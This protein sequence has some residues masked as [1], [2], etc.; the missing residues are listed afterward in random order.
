MR[1]LPGGLGAAR[2]GMHTV[3]EMRDASRNDDRVQ[4]VAF[5]LVCASYL[6]V[7]VGEQLL[8]P[9]FPVARD[10]LGLTLGDGGIAFGVLTASIAVANLL[11]GA[12]LTRVGPL[13]AIQAS[14]VATMIGSVIAAT[15]DGLGQ[16]VV[17]QVFMGLGAGLFFPGGLQLIAR[18]AG[19]SR[20][21]MA[22]GMYGVAFSIALTVAAVLGAI[23]AEQGWRSA[24]WVGGAIGVVALVVSLRIRE[25]REPGPHPGPIDWRAVAGLPTVV[26]AVGAVCQYGSIP[27]LTTFAVDRWGLREASAAIVLAAGRVIS[28]VAKL[29]A[30]ASADRIGPMRSAQRTSVV[31]VATGLGWALLPGGWVTYAIAAVF[32][33]TVSSLFPIAN[34]LAVERFG[35]HGGALGAYRSAQIGIGALAGFLIGIVGERI[36]LRPVLAVASLAPLVLVWVCRRPHVAV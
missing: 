33:G 25:G 6:A 21:G 5:V 9:L 4:W 32:A 15:A 10:D 26:G 23:G 12:W 27:F 14:T 8:S 11:G 19:P 20:R 35:R 28:I 1:A 13:T 3:Y 17:A 34:L 7:T 2:R 30:G 24:F 18:I 22:M 29:V 36:G 16:L 31:L